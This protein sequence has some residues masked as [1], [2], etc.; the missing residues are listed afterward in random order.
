[1]RDGSVVDATE[2]DYGGGGFVSQALF[3]LPDFNGHRPVLASWIVDGDPAGLGIRE[4]GLITDN[5]AR[6]VPHVIAP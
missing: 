5:T 1:M 3:E 4:G 6:F 2:G